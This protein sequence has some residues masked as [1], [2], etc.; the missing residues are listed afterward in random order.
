MF[1][2]A[3]GPAAAGG[4]APGGFAPPMMM[5]MAQGGGGTG[6]TAP[7]GFG[8]FGAGMAPMPMPMSMVMPMGGAGAAGYGIPGL[9]G[10]GG[11]GGGSQ[12]EQQQGLW[13]WVAL[14]LISAGL[15]PLLGPVLLDSASGEQPPAPLEGM[16]RM[17]IES[18]VQPSYRFERLAVAAPS[19]EGSEACQMDYVAAAGGLYM[20]ASS[21]QAAGMSCTNIYI[22]IYIYIYIHMLPWR[23]KVC[24]SRCGSVGSMPVKENGG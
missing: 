18:S 20:H 14:A 1:S 24:M 9:G 12:G 23:Y 3:A 19:E 7:A 2:A 5:M 4:P 22:Y 13:Q 6:P 17:D 10:G 21:L 11:V 15:A 8:G 16:R